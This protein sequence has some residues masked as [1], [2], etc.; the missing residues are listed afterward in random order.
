MANTKKA[1]TTEVLEDNDV[2]AENV[3]LKNQIEEMKKQMEQV[4]NQIAFLKNPTENTSR[5]K[6]KNIT[7][8][9][10]T[11]GVLVLKGSQIWKL[12]GQFAEHKF[13]EREAR[14]IVSN[15]QN[16]IR[17]G[18]VYIADRDF[19]EDNDLGEIYQIILDDK[20]LK[21]L[22][23]KRFDEIIEI[24]KLVPQGQK[25]IIVSMLKERKA[26]GEPVDANVLIEIGK[27]AGVDLLN[28]MPPEDEE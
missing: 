4:M 22:L 21:T 26:N 20:G 19:V 5:T 18:Y 6:E 25:D 9:N 28:V 14:L 8:V 17:L 3:A 27:L 12:E 24:Y 2:V 7:F 15:M 13:L 23:S 11:N 10:M 16:A 1:K